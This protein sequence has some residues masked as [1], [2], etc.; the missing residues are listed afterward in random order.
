MS[1][2]RN[3]AGSFVWNSSAMNS[4]FCKGSS[5]APSSNDPSSSDSG[6]LRNGTV[7]DENILLLMSF[8]NEV[9]LKMIA[10]LPLW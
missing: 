1:F 10:G 8:Q 2:I 9:A 7:A 3:N 5:L 4:K 6:G